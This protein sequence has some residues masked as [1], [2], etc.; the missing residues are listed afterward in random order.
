[1]KRWWDEGQ[2][3]LAL[4]V[5]CQEHGDVL[6]THAGLTRGQWR[7]L[8]SPPEPFAAA[9][10]LNA[11]VGKPVNEVIHGG[12]LADI[13]AGPDAERADVTWAEVID[14]LYGPWLAA[15]DAPFSQIHGHASPWNWITGTWW[16]TATPSVRAATAVDTAARRTTTYLGPKLATTVDWTLGSQPSSRVWPL[17]ILNHPASTGAEPGILHTPGH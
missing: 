3:Q 7:R 4:A 10:L 1:M 6:I 8:G 9:N 5:R 13:D 14:E 15:G 12:A 11:D 16:P 2:A 17:L